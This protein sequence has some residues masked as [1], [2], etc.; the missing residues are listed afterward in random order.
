M[1]YV[2]MTLNH[3]K[4]LRNLFAMPYGS[5]PKEILQLSLSG[6]VEAVPMPALENSSVHALLFS[7]V[8]STFTRSSDLGIKRHSTTSAERL[9]NLVGILT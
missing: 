3:A 6:C 2:K 4:D 1:I 9:L 8:K 5:F 7:G